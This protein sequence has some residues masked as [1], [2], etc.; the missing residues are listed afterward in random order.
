MAV[1]DSPQALPRA[2]G[3][4]YLRSRYPEPL[5]HSPH[6][7]PPVPDPGPQRLGGSSLGR[8]CGLLASL[9]ASPRSRLPWA[10]SRAPGC[11]A[12]REDATSGP[13]WGTERTPCCQK[14]CCQKSFKVY[15]AVALCLPCEPLETRSPVVTWLRRSPADPLLTRAQ[16]PHPTARERLPSAAWPPR[17]AAPHWLGQDGPAPSR[18]RPSTAPPPQAPP[19]PSLPASPNH[20]APRS[21]T[22]GKL[23]L[24]S[25]LPGLRQ[26]SEVIILDP[27]SI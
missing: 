21:S 25:A 4:D 6:S 10:Q 2:L 27:K 18:P 16:P 13:G 7:D 3:G 1:P 17:A 19:L 12:R 15:F 11:A 14:S 20:A 26:P 8:K 22:N 5:R 24:R 9:P 23:L